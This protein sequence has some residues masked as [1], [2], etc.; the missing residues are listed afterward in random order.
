MQT[1]R[2]LN[3]LMR[4]ADCHPD[5]KH[6]GRG[7]CCSCYTMWRVKVEPK[8]Q[9]NRNRAAGRYYTKHKAA[10]NAKMRARQLFTKFG[11]TL[12]TYALLLTAQGGGC[13]LCYDT[14]KP[15]RRLAVD[16]C[17]KTGRIRGLLCWSCNYH[18]LGKV[19]K[20]PDYLDRIKIYLTADL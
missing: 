18:V 3:G 20:Y 19:D 8:Y 7:L 2:L 4:K 9:E 10:C 11:M 14:P 12:E 13:A 6:H 5:R 17:H 1:V 15:N 16:H